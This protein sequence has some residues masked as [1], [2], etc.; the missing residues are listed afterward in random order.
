MVESYALID[1]IIIV[2]FF[3]G[4]FAAGCEETRY[5]VY[6]PGGAASGSG[7]SGAT[8]ASKIPSS[9]D[10]SLC[11]ASIIFSSLIITLLDHL[12]LLHHQL[13]R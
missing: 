1:N 3:F 7:K 13:L 4:V 9:A 6:G 5:E 10:R 12:R 11:V 8:S 2:N